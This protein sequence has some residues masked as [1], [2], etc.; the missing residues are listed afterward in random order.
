MK[1][2]DKALYAALTGDG[3]LTGKLSSAAAVYRR[4]APPGA[5][6]PYV[7]FAKQTGSDDY[8]FSQRA[9]S[10]MPYLVKAVDKSLSADN[11]NDIA[12][13]IDVLLTDVALT[14]TGKTLM[15]LRRETHVEYDEHA[16]G[17]VVYQHVGGIFRIEVG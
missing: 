10:S 1:A 2:V 14:V 6:C 16:A 13:R 9:K 12:D 8:T 3:T 17:G 11:A 15:Y 7:M 4:V 5:V